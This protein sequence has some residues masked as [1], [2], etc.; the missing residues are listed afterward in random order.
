MK[1]FGTC[2]I[3]VRNQKIK[4]TTSGWERGISVGRGSE[5]PTPGFT[6]V[7]LRHRAP[8][9]WSSALGHVSG[10]LC[11][12][13]PLCTDHFTHPVATLLPLQCLHNG[14]IK[15]RIPSMM[16]SKGKDWDRQATS[17]G[18]SWFQAFCKLAAMTYSRKVR[19]QLS[20][21]CEKSSEWQSKRKSLRE[22]LF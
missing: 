11:S 7:E 9:S 6:R 8:L 10:I 12:P 13:G 1:Y 18:R 15:G 5:R 20:V 16:E 22:I 4:R 19:R 14:L 3:R 17:T 21:S 2:W